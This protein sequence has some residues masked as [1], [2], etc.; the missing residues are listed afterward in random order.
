MQ[1]C[2]PISGGDRGHQKPQD[3]F[4]Y[5]KASLAHESRNAKDAT[6]HNLLTAWRPLAER[7]PADEPD[8]WQSDHLTCSRL[9]LAPAAAL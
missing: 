9:E 3:A 4:A 5:R 8:V 1:T 7:Q 6:A 2:N